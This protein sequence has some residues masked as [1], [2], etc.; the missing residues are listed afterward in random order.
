MFSSCITASIKTPQNVIEVQN[1][2]G[3]LVV[4]YIQEKKKRLIS[5]GRTTDFH[6]TQVNW[7]T[8]RDDG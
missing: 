4:R 1:T 3:K 6:A 8:A 2:G 7:V 5:F